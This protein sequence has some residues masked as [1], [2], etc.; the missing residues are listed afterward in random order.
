M[1]DAPQRIVVIGP[2]PPFRG[3]IAQ[4]TAML[5]RALAGHAETRVVSFKRLYPAWLF[6]GA[7]DR[8]A[9]AVPFNGPPCAFVIDTL[10]PV[11]W[12][13]AARDVSA[14]KPD[15]VLIPWWTFFLAP[16]LAWLARACRAKGAD[17]RFVCHNVA[18][19]EAA[20]WKTAIA[21][22]VLKQGNSYLTHTR[23][24]AGNLER[25][26][27]GAAI[28]VHPHPIYDQFPP[29]ARTLP[30]RARLE[31]LF[32]GLV[33]PYKGLDV[34]IEAMGLLEDLD[35]KLSVVGEFWE[36]REATERRIRDLGLTERVEL[37]PRYVSDAEA[38]NYF[39]RADA[40][41]LPYRGATGSGVIAVA[42]H[43]DKPV[44]ASEVGGVPDVVTE[45]ATGRLVPPGD[46]GAL[47][48]AIRRLPEMDPAATRAAIA[49]F[50]ATLT[51]DHLARAFAR[52]Q[53]R[54]R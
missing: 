1:T 2:V 19:H 8:D 53:A 52:P 26:I 47:A 25:L 3:G 6:P 39:A 31:L 34:L 54:A 24:D 22:L 18:D 14:F 46:A 15:L 7:S 21:R 44:I 41:V 23:A 4:H 43:Y 13:W 38:A 5:A 10:N 36:G 37:V 20:W 33:R 32:F 51:W 50:K 45:G 12:S 27:P 9:E 40:V 29:P 30:R 49:A 16:C 28:I 48:E 17:V 11:T 35:V 42:Y